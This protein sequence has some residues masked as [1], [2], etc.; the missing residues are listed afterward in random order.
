MVMVDRSLPRADDGE[1]LPE[2]PPL[3]RLRWLVTALTLVLIV[4]VVIIVGALVM[5]ITGPAAVQA[6]PRME[7]ERISVPA[8]ERITAT[9]AATGTLIVV[10]EDAGGQERLRVY[11]AASGALRHV[12]LIDR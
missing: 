3:R 1:D 2:P 5:R 12:T 9:G 7:A 4:G 10:T 8:G 6:P 11:D